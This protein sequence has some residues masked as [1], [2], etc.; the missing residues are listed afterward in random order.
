MLI[1]GIAAAVIGLGVFWVW[2]QVRLL[3]NEIADLK[4]KS[5]GYKT[6]LDKGKE[7]QAKVDQVDKW[8]RTDVVWLDEL[9]ELSKD[10]P[11]SKDVVL[12]D[13]RF[14][15]KA[16]SASSIDLRGVVSSASTIGAIDERLQD[17][18]H[19]VI[20]KN[21]DSESKVPSYPWNFMS[22]LQVNPDVPITD[23]QAEGI[24]PNTSASPAGEGSKAAPPAG[25]GTTAVPV[26][27]ATK[28]MPAGETTKAAL[29]GESTVDN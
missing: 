22:S 29:V 4:A 27:E 6:I 10:L 25:A 28:E 24:Q 1:G 16:G 14:G 21:V 13:L 19:T 15:A 26:G 11:E 9:Y 5:A 2:N 8:A 23:I 18:R 20:A 3:D 12:A 17:K 7:I